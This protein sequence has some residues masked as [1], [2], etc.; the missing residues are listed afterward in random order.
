MRVPI[1]DRLFRDYL[2]CKHKTFLKLSGENGV[3][4][5]FAKIQDENHE[6]YCQRAREHLSTACGSTSRPS[7]NSTFAEII[8]QNL[9]VAVSISISTNKYSL[10][11]DAV[12]LASQ[13]SFRRPVYNP[14]TIGLSLSLS[15]FARVNRLIIK[16]QR[17]PVSIQSD[18]FFSPGAVMFAG[19]HITGR[20]VSGTDYFILVIIHSIR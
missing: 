18:T 5:D 6:E 9:S 11:L 20:A 19:C 12:E 13:S 7:V 3:K 8:K 1:S 15:V 16:Q 10:I 4:S 14:I 2:Q 17:A